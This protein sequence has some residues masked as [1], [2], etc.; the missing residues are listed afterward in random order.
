MYH[1]ELTYTKL[2][3]E[4]ETLRA[5]ADTERLARIDGVYARLPRIREI[6]N[7]IYRLGTENIKNIFH[8]PEKKAEYNDKLKKNIHRLEAEKRKLLSEN[9]IDL[10]FDKPKYECA[11]CEDTG[12]IDGR[13]CKC[14]R[15]KLINAGYLQSNIARLLSAQNFDTFRFDLYDDN[16]PTDERVSPRENMQT[17]VREC[18]RFCDSFE[19]MTQNLLFYGTTG[20]GKTFLS[21]CIAKELIDR[22]YTVVYTRAVHLFSMYEDYKFGRISG[23]E[24]RA[25]L[26]RI[27]DADLLIIDDLGTEADSKNV[28]AYFYDILESRLLED[29]KMVVSTNLTLKEISARYSTRFTSRI[30]EYFLPLRFFGKDIRVKQL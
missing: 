8:N 20:L 26:D 27:Y 1:D 12:Y 2:L 24:I 17:I 6:D 23:E 15:Q 14:F 7:E 13:K 5:K 4:Y 11:L 3:A 9:D 19:G 18:H 25:Q 16:I 29:K 10:D 21:S 22:G 28:R 30:Y